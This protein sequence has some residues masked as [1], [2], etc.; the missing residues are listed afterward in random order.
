MEQP[1]Y[2]YRFGLEPEAAEALEASSEAA[3]E[4]GFPHGVSIRS[5]N[6][7][8]D[9]SVAPRAELELYFRVGQTGGADFT[10]LWSCLI[11]L[12]RRSQSDSMRSLGEKVTYP[13]GEIEQIG[14]RTLTILLDPSQDVGARVSA[15]H[16]LASDDHPAAIE[17]LTR[18]AQQIDVPQELASEVGRSLG[19]LC[20]RRAQD[21]HDLDM[22]MFSEDADRAYDMEIGRLQR[23]APHVKMR[24]AV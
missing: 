6:Y 20:F 22:A 4:R 14:E 24:R 3:A 17:A 12:P 5:E 11:P 18:V 7:R 10:S 19:Q 1:E 16:E 8:A 13:M 2:F 9:A 23:L 15:A 21:V